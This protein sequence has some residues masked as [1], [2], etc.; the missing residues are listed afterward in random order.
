GGGFFAERA[1]WP[2]EVEVQCLNAGAVKEGAGILRIRPIHG[3]GVCRA[4][5][6]LKVSTLGESAPLGY[7]D[8]LRPPGDHPRGSA[9]PR[10]PIRACGPPCRWGWLPDPRVAATQPRAATP[11]ARAGSLSPP[12]LADHPNAPAE[13]YDFR[14]PFG[15]TPA[16]PA[17][18]YRSPPPVDSPRE[19]F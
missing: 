5:F 13:P 4:D 11:P 7:S 19:D 10:W 17:P 16:A 14:R 18:R 6:P 15:A 3:P 9:P 8:E 12:G 2:H 1:P